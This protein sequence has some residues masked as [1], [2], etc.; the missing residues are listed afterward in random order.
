MHKR[1]F[2]TVDPDTET[3]LGSKDGR[4]ISPVV[5][6]RHK[7]IARK[8]RALPDSV[9]QEQRSAAVEEMEVESGNGEAGESRSPVERVLK[10]QESDA[11]LFSTEE[12]LAE[13]FENMNDFD[14]GIELDL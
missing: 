13:E 2:G 10:V 11:P 1:I 7:I 8:G 14:V 5:D 9:S 6:L 4:N 3:D 12:K